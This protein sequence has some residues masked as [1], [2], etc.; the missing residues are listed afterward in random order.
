VVTEDGPHPPAQLV[1]S[2]PGPNIVVLAGRATHVPEGAGVSGIQRTVTV[3]PI[4]PVDW[5]RGSD[6]GWGSRPK[7]HGMQGVKFSE[8]TAN[9]STPQGG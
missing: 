1:P 7:L 3:T 5:T 4:E 6:L 2:L 8:Q 9:R